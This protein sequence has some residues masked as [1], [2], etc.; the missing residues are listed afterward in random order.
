VVYVKRGTRNPGLRVCT[1]SANSN[2]GGQ[3]VETLWLTRAT[4]GLT[5]LLVSC[6]I[7]A[8][9]RQRNYDI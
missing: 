2:A 9:E 5:A 3:E 4:I 7:A 6:N 1:Q 8:D